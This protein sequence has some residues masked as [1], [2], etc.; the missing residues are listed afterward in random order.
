[1]RQDR[2]PQDRLVQIA[3]LLPAP[4]CEPGIADGNDQCPCGSGQVWP[5]N[6]TRAAWL[7]RGLD[8]DAEIRKVLDKAK[9]A[10]AAETAEWE[11]LSETD[12]GAARSDALRRLGW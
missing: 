7:A 9:A 8:P 3:G 11:A 2:Q 12:P 4:C 10:I 5:C 1:M 6:I